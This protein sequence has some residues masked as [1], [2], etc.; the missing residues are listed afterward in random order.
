MKTFWIGFIKGFFIGYAVIY[1]FY[2][3]DNARLENKLLQREII[4]YEVTND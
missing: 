4:A 2:L 1:A 3:L